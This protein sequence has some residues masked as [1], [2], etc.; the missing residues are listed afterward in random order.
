MSQVR[1]AGAPLPGHNNPVLLPIARSVMYQV[2]RPTSRTIP[3]TN[4]YQINLHL[5]RLL[6]P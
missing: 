3:S 6:S 4:Q 2:S 1:R 5:R